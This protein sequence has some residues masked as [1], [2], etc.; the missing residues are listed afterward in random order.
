MALQIT[1]HVQGLGLVGT[2]GPGYIEYNGEYCGMA[3]GI[4]SFIPY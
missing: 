4:H 1:L 2:G 3:I